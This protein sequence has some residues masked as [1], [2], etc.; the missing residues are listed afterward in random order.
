MKR[1]R[2]LIAVV[3]DDESV[4][5]ALTRVLKVSAF[6]VESYSS[7]DEF[8]DSLASH[9]PDCVILDFQLQG[10]TAHS[11]LKQ[12]AVSG[13][14]TPVIV[15][16]AHADPALKE[17]CLAAGAIAYLNKPLGRDNLVAVINQAIDRSDLPQSD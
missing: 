12:L 13:I 3:D 4:R 9:T 15:V 2:P 17:Q 10:H 6:D 5:R 11:V 7:G 14:N 1:E 16:T 8:I